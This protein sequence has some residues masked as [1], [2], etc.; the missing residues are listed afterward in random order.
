M[1]TSRFDCGLSVL[2]KHYEITSEIFDRMEKN[3]KN[4]NK[5]IKANPNEIFLLLALKNEHSLREAEG[6]T[7]L[8]SR[9]NTTS[10][11]KSEYIF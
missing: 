5:I 11:N 9:H 3:F 4:K 7:H 6:Q 1:K 10:L 8:D 2:I